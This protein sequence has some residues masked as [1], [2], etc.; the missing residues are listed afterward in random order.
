M[1]GC[2]LFYCISFELKTVQ[3]TSFVNSTIKKLKNYLFDNMENT[4]DT[5]SVPKKLQ[6]I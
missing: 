3:S 1:L 5:N 4:V 6:V 2:T